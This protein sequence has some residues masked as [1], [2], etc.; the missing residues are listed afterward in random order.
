MFRLKDVGKKFKWGGLSKKGNQRLGLFF[1]HGT[2]IGHKAFRPNY[3]KEG[4]LGRVRW[5]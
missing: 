3:Q 1:G 5:F 2:Q 4:P